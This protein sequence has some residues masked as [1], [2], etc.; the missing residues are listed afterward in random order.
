MRVQLLQNNLY[1]LVFYV[2]KTTILSTGYMDFKG[3]EQHLTS[4]FILP[5]ALS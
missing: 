5:S 4:A 2:G 1:R 3:H